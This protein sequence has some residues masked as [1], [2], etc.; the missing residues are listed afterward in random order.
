MAIRAAA[1]GAEVT[2]VDLAPAMLELARAKAPGL[3][4]EVG[5][6]QALAYPDGAFDVVSS[7]FGS[8][9]A[10]DHE[11]VARE[12]ARVCRA[13]LGLTAWVRDPALGEVYAACGLD[14]PEGRL[15]FEWGQP[16]HVEELLGAAFELE[17]ER[18]T[19]LLEGASGEDVWELWSRS[20]PPFKALVES[21]DAERR[22]R[23]RE[24]YVAYCESHRDG[25][26]VRVPRDYLLVLGRRR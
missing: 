5:D 7:C 12:L 15:P 13:R 20:A 3:R 24:G 6:C 22:E 8:I 16:E 19:W 23:F 17:L 1:A 2:G 11:A 14:T 21:L 9:F 4:F 18:H 10:P 26:R 25:D